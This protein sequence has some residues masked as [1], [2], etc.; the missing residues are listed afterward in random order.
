[1]WTT[2]SLGAVL[3]MVPMTSGDVAEGGD[4]AHWSLA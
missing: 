3:K 1:M 4:A 2:A